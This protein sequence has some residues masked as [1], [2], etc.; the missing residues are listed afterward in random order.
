[1]FWWTRKPLASARAVIL[2]S[3]LSSDFD[4]ERFIRIIFPSYKGRGRFSKTPHFLNPNLKL[5][6]KEYIEK[7]KRTRLLDPFAG[8]GSIPLE[9]IRLGVGE[10]VASEL[11]PTAVV[12]LRAVLEY[13]K[14]AVEKKIER[15]LLNDVE[16]WGRW[17]LEELKKDPDV[18]ELYDPDV[19]VYIGTWEIKCPYCGRYTPLIGNWW[20]A[21]VKGKRGFKSL[22]WMTPVK[23][24]RGVEIKIE[25]ITDRSVLQTAKTIR[26]G[27]R[28]IGIEIGDKKIIIGDPA[29]NGE[30]NID[31][32]ANKAVCLYCH[33][34]IKGTKEKWHVKEGLREWNERLERY[35]N[36]EISLEELRQSPARPRLLVKVRI[37][38]KELEF[39]PAKPEDDEKLWKAFEK[40]K[41]LWGDPDI[42]AESVPIYENRS[43]WVIVYGFDKWYK[44]FNPRQ[45]ITLVKLVKLI[46]EAGKKIEE[47]KQKEGWS[48]EEAFKYA[49]AVTT[50]LGICLSNSADFNSLSTYWEVVWGT[51]KRSVAF[52]GIAM[53][54]NWIDLNVI[55]RTPGSWVRSVETIL[56]G[57]KYIITA[58]S[59]SISQTKVLLDDTTSLSKLANEKFDLIITDPPYRD[60]VPYAELSDFY[61][62][63][64]KRALSDNDGV[65]LK[66]R[67]HVDLFFP[68]GVEISTQWEWFASREVSLSEG[69]CEYFKMGAGEDCERVYE[70]LLKSSF[71]SMV[72]RLNEDG[73]LITYFAQSSPEAWSSLLEA[74]LSNGL[75]PVVAFPVITESEESVISRGKSA[76]SA[77]I[78]IAWRKIKQAEP[79]DIS[80]KYDELIEKAVK[81]L[82]DVEKALA[83]AGGD[84]V[85]ELYGV[86]IYVMTYARILSLLAS[87]G[88]P[89]K[90][91]RPLDS[92]EIA[93]LASEILAR[94]YVKEAG[95]SL[96]HEDSIFYLVVKKVFPRGE[97]GRRLASS[98]DLILLSYGVGVKKERALEDL[99]RRGVLKAYGR[100]EETEVASRKT[101]MLI[102]PAKSDDETE[103]SQILKMHN[104][105]P[106]NPA[107]FKSPVHVLHALMLYALKPKDVFTKYYERIYLANPSLVSEAV[108]LA[109]ALTTLEGDP[110][111]ELASRVIEYL[112]GSFKNKRGVSLY[113]FTKH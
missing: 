66:P 35:L 21:R 59:N 4:V 77:S 93:R 40:V 105:Y 20:L 32:Q 110:E 111:A 101:Y 107:T 51:N 28:T 57:L 84:V 103:L 86:T 36:G 15:Q 8:F 25:K 6:N 5:L 34:N 70:R 63:W 24:E 13:P 83:R 12:F 37:V 43:I 64:L 113:D 108:E 14:T 99:E 112:G 48:K 102:E 16:R 79:L 38:N 53:T 44:L 2:A 54:W 58:I 92:R 97:E 46:R 52:R 96:S 60:D 71:N 33:A 90:A 72:E 26:R 22:A 88:R 98:S 10:V 89:V 41:T 11:L 73:V 50:Y 29:L 75:F 74:G 78:V 87:G 17:V 55:K 27:R 91:G 56:N 49:E 7:I 3:L 76:I 81:A 9:A 23:T 109:K 94:A 100:E 68:G 69:R 45:L 1:V 80:V 62:V 30:P 18:K 47:E 85:S 95:A 31:A 67:F 106:E 19:A 65:T 42:P 104:I 61:Y 82:R 39:E